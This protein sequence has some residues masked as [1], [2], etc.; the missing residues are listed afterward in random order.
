MN[1][2]LLKKTLFYTVLAIAALLFLYPFAWMIAVSVRP[3]AEAMR[4]GLT[5][6]T[7]TLENLRLMMDKIPIWRALLNSAIVSF[8]STISVLVLSSMAGYALSRLRFRGRAVIFSVILFTMMIPFQIT[9]IPLYVL[10]VKLNLTDTYASLIVPFTM[11]PFAILLFRQFFQQVPQD[12][13]D[14]ARIDGLGELGILFRIF[15]PLSRPALITVGIV[16]FMTIWNE[17]LWPIIVVRKRE[18]MTMP[19][20]VALFEVGGQ[21]ENLIAVKLAAASV[22]TIPI[23]L[24]Y[25]VLQRYFIESMATSGLK[26]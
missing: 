20:M 26:G 1:M 25:I 22:M 17:V 23:V 15:W 14:A 13:I 11:T 21:A 7:F 6:S 5:G 12:L 2:A 3:E 4:I 18:I 16:H 8:V 10:M 9:L 24:I 19:Q